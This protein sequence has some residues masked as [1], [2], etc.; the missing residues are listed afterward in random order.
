MPNK[1][2]LVL[3]NP[4]WTPQE[5]PRRTS[6]L[7]F[8]EGLERCIGSFNIYH[9]NFYELQGFR[10]ALNFDLTQTNEDRLFLYIASHGQGKMVGGTTGFNGIQLSSLLKVIRNVAGPNNLEGVVIG[11]CEVG[12]NVG[13]F[14]D[15]MKNSHLRWIFGYT[16]S[17]HWMPSMMVDLAILE[18]LMEL[19]QQ[20]LNSNT[21]IINAF[22]RSLQRFN[23][24]YIIGD[25]AGEAVPLKDAI[26]L[27][28]QSKGQGRKPQDETRALLE[29][30]GWTDD[31][32]EEQI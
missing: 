24:N 6:V 21:K 22:A 18:H 26:S 9:A 28:I 10:Y 16:C 23:G 15:T 1:A 7:P 2:L 27:V 30:L 4:W 31:D 20:H 13:D 17:I 12:C 14:M 3:E 5:N 32:R 11:S 29:K 8:I 25:N 19:P